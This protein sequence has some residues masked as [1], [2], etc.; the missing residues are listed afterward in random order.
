MQLNHT[1]FVL[2]WIVLL[3]YEIGN[4]ATSPLADSKLA[5]LLFHHQMLCANERKFPFFFAL[6]H[7]YCRKMML[8]DDVVDHV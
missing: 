1:W 5:L 7:L 2:L 6:F 3:I 8:F 4:L